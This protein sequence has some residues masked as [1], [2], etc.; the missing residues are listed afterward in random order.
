VGGEQ[1]AYDGGK[2]VKGRKQHILV[3]TEGFVLK[4]KVHSAKVMDFERGSRR[5]WIG[6][7]GDF[8]A[9]VTCGWMPATAE[10]IRAQTGSRRHW[11]GA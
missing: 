8:L 6:H 3:D 9:S 10:R 1:R 7:R 2:K 5:C 11:G 4:V